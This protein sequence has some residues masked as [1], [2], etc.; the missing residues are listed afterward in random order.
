M[1]HRLTCDPLARYE[2]P[3]FNPGLTAGPLVLIEYSEAYGDVAAQPANP[4]VKQ[5]RGN[6]GNNVSQSLVTVPVPVDQQ[7]LQD[8]FHRGF[9]AHSAYNGRE[10][11][12]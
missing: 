4:I 8:G 2:T 3:N 6:N 5:V 7:H 11:E 1:Q 12:Q 9:S 10:E